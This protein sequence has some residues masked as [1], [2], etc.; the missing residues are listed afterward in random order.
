MVDLVEA[1]EHGLFDQHPHQSDHQRRDEQGRPV[2]HVE[3][4]HAEKRAQLGVAEQGDEGA[5]HVEGAVGEVDDVEQAEDDGQP[6]AEQGIENAVVQSE[7]QLRQDHL[8]G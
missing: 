6:Q 2:I 1:L 3:P 8:W 7:H 4:G 5:E